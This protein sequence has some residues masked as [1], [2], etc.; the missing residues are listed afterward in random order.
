MIHLLWAS[1]EKMF[2]LS[3]GRVL[4]YC[5]VQAL[6]TFLWHK[7]EPDWAWSQLRETQTVLKEKLSYNDI[8]W[9]LIPALLEAA[10]TLG[11]FQTSTFLLLFKSVQ[12]GFFCHFQKK[13]KTSNWF[14]LPLTCSVMELG[15]RGLIL[16]ESDWSRVYSFESSRQLRA[17]K[18]HIAWLKQVAITTELLRKGKL[19]EFPSGPVV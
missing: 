17:V 19:G 18:K 15:C 2:T 16:W 6:A 13:K 3:L 9:L 11:H 14:D 7:E 1:R 10:A 4:W 5:E 12:T 8:I